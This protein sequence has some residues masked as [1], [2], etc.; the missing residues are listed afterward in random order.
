MANLPLN[1]L[2]RLYYKQELSTIEIAK[3]FNTNP[4]IVQKFMIKNGLP[5]RTFEEANALVFSRKPVT[6]LIKRN[7]SPKE[8]QLKIAGIML[9]WAEGNKETKR[10]FTIDFSNSDPKMIH[11]FLKFLRNI[12]GI[13]E[14]RLRVL[15]Y[16]YA[17]QDV[18]SLK[19]Y[20]QKITKIPSEQFIKPYV[21][22]D[23][24]PEKSGKMKFG[25]THVRYSDKKLFLKIQEWLR[26]YLESNN[27]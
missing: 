11:V 23:F 17:N 14:N 20:W 9:Y 1:L 15:L 5:R 26:E 16:C 6:F 8:K 25:L 19:R 7:L 21:R 24:L 12:C 22:K 13:D 2:K 3:R 4:W 18:K 10:N 27:I